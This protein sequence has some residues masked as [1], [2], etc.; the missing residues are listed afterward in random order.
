M[1]TFPFTFC[2]G[3]R[4]YRVTLTDPT[5]DPIFLE[6]PN[7]LSHSCRTRGEICVRSDIGSDARREALLR[8]VF[9]VMLDASGALGILEHVPREEVGE[10]VVSILVPRLFDVIRDPVN[11][12]LL[13]VLCLDV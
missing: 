12:V 13:N 8:E 9:H 4:T 2:V 10:V 6:R 1:S 7:A 11:R 3:A 5:S